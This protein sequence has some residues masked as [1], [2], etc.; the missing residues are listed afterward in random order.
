MIQRKV[1]K[2]K[3]IY[4]TPLYHFHAL[5]KHLE[6]SQPGDYFKLV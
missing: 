5:H 4:V 3:T 2:G 6:I 1:G